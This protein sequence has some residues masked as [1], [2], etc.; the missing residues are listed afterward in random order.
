MTNDGLRRFFEALDENVDNVLNQDELHEAFQRTLNDFGVW[1]GDRPEFQ[2]YWE[3]TW[4]KVLDVLAGM[5]RVAPA[6]EGEEQV[7][8]D[9]FCFEAF[10]GLLRRLK[11]ELALRVWEKDGSMKIMP[12]AVQKSMVKI[13]MEGNKRPVSG[14]G[15]ESGGF[16]GASSRAS[17]TTAA[18]AAA[19]RAR[20]LSTLIQLEEEEVVLKTYTWNARTVTGLDVSRRHMREFFLCH[21]GPQWTM[22]WIIADSSDRA[23]IIRL[24]IKYRF[25]PLHLEDVLKLERQQPRFLKYGGHYFVILPLL[26]LIPEESGN[27]EGGEGGGPTG[28]GLTGSGEGGGGGLG[29]GARTNGLENIAMEKSRIAIFASGPPHFDTIISIHGAWR[30]VR[31]RCCVHPPSGS[32]SSS[33]DAGAA[34]TA[35]AAAASSSSDS[36]HPKKRK[37]SLEMQPIGEGTHDTFLTPSIVP[38]SGAQG[39]K[40][41]S[42]LAS[43]QADSTENIIVTA[44]D[45]PSAADGV[46]PSEAP[47]SVLGETA[48]LLHEDYSNVRHGNSNWCLHAMVETT[49]KML[50]PIV[51]AYDRRLRLFQKELDGPDAVRMRERLSKPIMDVKQ[52]LIW[53]QKRVKSLKPV[54]RSLIGEPKLAG[55]GGGEVVFY[56]QGVDDDLEILFD[57]INTMLVLAQG[58]LDESKYLKDDTRYVEA[59]SFFIDLGELQR[60]TLPSLLS[61][62]LSRK[63]KLTLLPPFLSA[64]HRN[65]ALKLFAVMTATFSPLQLLTG[66]FGTNFWG[67]C[68][69]RK[70]GRFWMCIMC[71]YPF[72]PF[73]LF[74]LT[75]LYQNSHAKT[76]SPSSFHSS[77][78][79]PSSQT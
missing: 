39:G 52:D 13:D 79:P 19:E 63:V 11:L 12:L 61:S 65:E 15:G 59:L 44:M 25:H 22:R 38:R 72:L 57:D 16:G 35:A 67:T 14:L 32:S 24:S 27:E 55:D 43:S 34:A 17:R 7:E 1:D 49:T 41:S 50:V 20:R 66:Y 45:D 33:T 76:S 51:A 29:K 2:A 23:N 75:N 74:L 9:P 5:V 4:S 46:G 30:R 71:L 21:R 58:L 26:R 53:L 68:G 73:F 10:A 54:M 40:W 70:R 36:H 69:K 28:A 60:H 78:P 56:L 18:I 31:N 3:A 8:M 77:L 42:L 64:F 47:T 37:G 62:P 6:S 48:R